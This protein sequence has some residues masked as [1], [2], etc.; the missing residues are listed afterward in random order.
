MIATNRSVGNFSKITILRQSNICVYIVLYIEN[1]IVRY[2]RAAAQ[3]D[4]VRVLVLDRY[5]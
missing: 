3:R 1:P 4:M 5:G 2:F